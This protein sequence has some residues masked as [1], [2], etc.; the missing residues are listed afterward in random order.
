MVLRILGV[1]TAVLLYV[2]TYAVLLAMAFTL[3]T[4][5]GWVLLPGVILVYYAMS[6]QAAR[7]RGE[8]VIGYVYEGVRLNMPLPELIASAAAG[9]RGRLRQTLERLAGELLNGVP[10]AEALNAVVTELDTAKRSLLLAASDMGQLGRMLARLRRRNRLDDELRQ[11]DMMFYWGYPL[12]VL[13]MMFVVLLGVCVLIVPKYEEIFVDFDT[14]LPTVTVMLVDWSKWLGGRLDPYQVVPGIAWFALAVMVILAL[15]A[16]MRF[17]FMQHLLDPIIWRLPLI[18]RL[19][20]ARAMGDACSLMGQSLAAGATVDEAILAAGRLRHSSLLSRRMRHWGHAVREGKPL[21]EAARAAHLPA[22]LV[23]LLGAS[24][25]GQKAGLP[26]ALRFLGRYYDAQGQWLKAMLHGAAVP[27]IVMSLA[28]VVGFV[29]TSL[30]MP[31]VT[32]IESQAAYATG[33]GL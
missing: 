17:A 4:P 22:M 6:R 13:G 20:R 3:V 23:S 33:V 29:V 31:L 24:G 8:V 9:E 7:R 27:V 32:L 15:V 30:F 5:V 11:P 28:V 25:G 19:H 14:Q 2:A 10:V 18:G 16:C 26:E 1:T 21:D 12:A